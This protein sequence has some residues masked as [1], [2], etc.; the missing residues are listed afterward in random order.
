MQTE[1][2]TEERMSAHISTLREMCETI[3]QC[4]SR[5]YTLRFKG[6]FRPHDDVERDG[7]QAIF[8]H[9][10]DDTGFLNSCLDHLSEEEEA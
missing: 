7:L 3:E 6:R 9:I 10:N 4:W 2:R 8:D 5:L 1:Q